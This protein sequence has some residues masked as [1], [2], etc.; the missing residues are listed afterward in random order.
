MSAALSI[1]LTQGP[2]A[3]HWAEEQVRG[4]GAGAVVEFH[5]DVRPNNLQGQ[6]VHHL[7]YE[8][9][10]SMV[11]AELRR[12]V[13]EVAAEYAILGVAVEHAVGKVPCG[14]RAVTV[15]V[16]AFHRKAAFLACSQIMDGLKDR[17]PLWKQEQV[18]DRK[19][20][21]REESHA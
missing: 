1:R 18:Q 15:A 3:G 8:A 9:H 7:E 11:R 6:T 19:E 16:S 10:E 14:K 5:G 12:I 21:S 13:D 4:Q 17:V 20:G 2:L